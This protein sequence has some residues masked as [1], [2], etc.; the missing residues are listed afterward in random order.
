MIKILVA[1]D[2]WVHKVLTA[3]CMT[4]LLAMVV[5]TVYTV[6]MR[7]IFENPPVWG[8]LLTVLS[9][10]WLVF[11]ALTLTVRRKEHIALNL[12][13]NYLPKKLGFIVQQFWT[14]VIL[15]LGVVIYYY[16]MEVVAKMGGKYWEMWH[17]MWQDGSIVFIPNYMP[18]SYAVTILPIAGAL[19]IIAAAIAIIED[20]V[21]YKNG[22]FK[23][24]SSFGE[25]E[26]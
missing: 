21:R 11:I 9:N 6:I 26:I 7:Y 22:N 20:I 4:M 23:L 8:D 25:E 12:I 14:L 16:G 5:F 15:S 2:R 10:I 19:I 17:F 13:Y 3:F 1:I 24:A 18:K